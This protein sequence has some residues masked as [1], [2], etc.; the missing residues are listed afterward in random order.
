[1]YLV[2]KAWLLYVMFAL[3]ICNKHKL[4]YT[5][6]YGCL[7]CCKELQQQHEREEQEIRNKKSWNTDYW[8]PGSLIEQY[9]KNRKPQ[10]IETLFYQEKK[11]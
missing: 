2:I 1:M 3:R 7:C 9:Y 8:Y 6:Q 10:N 5:A 11:T 4:Y